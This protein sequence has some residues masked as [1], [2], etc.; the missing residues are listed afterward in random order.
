MSNAY[1]N[2]YVLAADSS[3]VERSQFLRRTYLHLAGA[4]LALIGLEAML[5][6]SPIALPMTKLMIGTQYAWLAVLALFMGASWLAQK[7]ALSGTS[8]GIQYAGL[9]LYVLAEAFVL[10][11]I[12]TIAVHYLNEPNLIAMAGMI[13]IGLFLGLTAIVVTTKKDFSFLGGILKVGSFVA[14][15]LIVASILFGFTLGTFFAAVMV[16]FV[17]AVILY[18]TS[19]IFNQYSTN[20][21]VAASLGLF[22]SVATMFFYVLQILIGRRN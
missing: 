16:L 12:L 15:G 22:A 7:W 11:P 14:L 18:Q 3:T 5:L 17:G 2:P 13:T 6:N 20:Q 21:Y 4:I 1:Q 9:G 19:A 10:M 8:L